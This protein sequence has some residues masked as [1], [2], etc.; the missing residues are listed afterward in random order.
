[1]QSFD[2][3]GVAAVGAGIFGLPFKREES[4]IVLLPVPWEV[5][6]SYGEGAA[7]GPQIIFDAS[8]QV[9][10]Y[11]FETGHPYEVGIFMEPISASIR[12]K[13]DQLKAKAAVAIAMQTGENPNVQNLPKLLTEINAGCAQLTQWVYEQSQ[14]ILSEGKALGLIGGDHSSPLGA[15]KAVSE[16][17]KGDFGVLHIDAHAD[18]RNSYEGFS[19]SHAS[20]M[21]NLMTAPFAP[22]KLV[23]IGIRDFCKEEHDFISKNP[24]TIKTFF[25]VEI[26][27]R[28]LSGE[29]W[30][31]ICAD[32]VS[33][34]PQNVYI[35]FDIDGLDPA[36]CPRT[37]TPVP[38]GLSIDQVYF[39]FW[40]LVESGRRVIAFD[41][42]EVSSGSENESEW[43]GNV[44]AR[45]LYKLCGWLAKGL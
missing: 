14:K 25:D 13:N 31:R 42:N 8:S 39:L 34:L 28:W 3:N 23:Q 2:P 5:T 16:K 6:T 33:H 32:V 29:T 7:N 27:R 30:A 36:M 38:G 37:G 9:D 45:I 26:K 11:D 20:I 19:E 35:S 15:F 21:Y 40:T 43:D 10:L 22:Q 17:F 24:K 18:L 41:I 12:E 1:M 4:K 44:G